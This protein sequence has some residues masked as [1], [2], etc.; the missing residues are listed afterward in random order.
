M[1]RSHG[2]ALL[3]AIRHAPICVIVMSVCLAVIWFPLGL[4][5]NHTYLVCTNQTT[6]EQIRGPS[7]RAPTPSTVACVELVDL[8]QEYLG[9]G[10][11]SHGEALLEAIRH[12]S[13]DEEMAYRSPT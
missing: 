6:Y 8:C 11:R 4:W 13:M 12:S 2:E 10:E 5:A 1:G 9:R 3:E 7:P